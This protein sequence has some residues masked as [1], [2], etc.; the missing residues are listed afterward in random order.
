[1]RRR[2]AALAEGRPG[3]LAEA[4]DE[5]GNPDALTNG[6]DT[7]R[8]GTIAA[9]I[10]RN[11]SRLIALASDDARFTVFQQAAATLVEAVA[12]QRIPKTLMVD[13]LHEIATPHDNFVMDQDALQELISGY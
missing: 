1:L 12:A 5:T 9:E 8:Y 6:T 4:V 11:A 2:A 3:A 10:L 13:R 7:Q